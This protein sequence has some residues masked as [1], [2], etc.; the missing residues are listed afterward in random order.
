MVKINGEEL[1]VAGKTISEYLAT[2]NY[3]TTRIAERQERQK[4]HIVCNQHRADERDD[5]QCNGCGTETGKPFDDA[6]GKT[7]EEADV[8]Q[9]TDNGE[10]AEQAGQRL[11]IKVGQVF[12]IRR[13]KNRGDTCRSKCNAEYGVL[14]QKRNQ[15]GQNALSVAVQRMLR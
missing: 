2:T 3:D 4:R 9:R 10:H 1:N 8:A 14:A 13:N 5:D 15:R 7:C 11:E 6:A 12:C